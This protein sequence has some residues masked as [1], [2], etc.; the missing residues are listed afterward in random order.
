MTG[1]VEPLFPS[2]YSADGPHIEVIDDRFAATVLAIEA[3]AQRIE[4]VHF[5][6]GV[7]REDVAERRP[8]AGVK[9]HTVVAPRSSNSLKVL[10]TLHAGV[11]A[12]EACVHFF[13]L[14]DLVHEAMSIA[15]GAEGS[16]RALR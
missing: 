15:P 14:F 7:L 6:H 5:Q 13:L 1:G 2:H 3:G 9:S 10:E 4:P 11:Q 12:F 16:Q 8:V